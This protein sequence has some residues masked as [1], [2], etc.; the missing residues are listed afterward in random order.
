MDEALPVKRKRKASGGRT[1]REWLEEINLA[2]YADK[3]MGDSKTKLM[4]ATGNDMLQHVL[5]LGDLGLQHFGIE[6][7]GHRCKI[8]YYAGKE[9]DKQGV[10]HSVPQQEQPIEISDEDSVLTIGSVLSL[11]VHCWFTICSLLG[12]YWLTIGCDCRKRQRSGK[13]TTLRWLTPSSLSTAHCGASRRVNLKRRRG[14]RRTT[15][16]VPPYSNRLRMERI[17]QQSVAMKRTGC[18]NRSSFL[19]Q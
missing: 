3:L 8:R 6:K 9:L 12:H 13:R 7:M 11:L 18:R 4:G 17:R 16:P 5:A 14:K 2:Q 15:P 10:A 19:R 1:L